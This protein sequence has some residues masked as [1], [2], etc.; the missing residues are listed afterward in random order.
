[1]R[2]NLSYVEEELSPFGFTRCN[3]CYIVNMQYVK[4]IEKNVVLVGN[5]ELT[6]SRGRQ[7]SFMNEFLA[8]IQRGGVLR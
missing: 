6:I 7:K 4:S 3:K 5:E 8:F 1:M 2:G